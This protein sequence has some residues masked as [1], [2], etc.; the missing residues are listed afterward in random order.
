[1]KPRDT[2]SQGYADRPCYP[3]LVAILLAGFL[4]VVTEL[5][6]SDSAA[7]IY[8]VVVSV[9]FLG[10]LVWRGRRSEGAVRAWGMRWDNFWPAL[11][12]QS[13]FGAVGALALIA[14]GVA[15]GSLV[16]PKSPTGLFWSPNASR[17]SGSAP[18]GATR[19]AAASARSLTAARVGFVVLAASIAAARVNV[20]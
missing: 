3:E 10:Y 12:A 1:M 19:C 14:F 2:D 6:F 15:T 7:R 5:G 20:S 11:R 9:V 18:A 17:G 16:L 8:N 4:H 13:I